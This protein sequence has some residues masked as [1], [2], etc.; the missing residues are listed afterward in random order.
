[1]EDIQTEKETLPSAAAN[2][3]VNFIVMGMAGSGNT[4]FVKRLVSHLQMKGKRHYS[5][6]L[7][8]AIHELQF[9]ANIDIRDSVNYKSIMK[10]Y[11]LGP[12]GGIITSL[13]LFAT[14]FDQVIHLIEKKQEEIDYVIIDT[15]GQIEVFSWSA[16]GQIIS[17][18][19]ACSFP[20]VIVYV[21][22]TVRCKNPNT[23][24][25]NMLYALSIMYKSKLPIIIVFNKVD[26]APHEFAV[27]WMKDFEEFEASLEQDQSYTSSLSR[28]MCLLLEEFY[29]NL[30]SCGVSAVTGLGLDEFMEASKLGVKEYFDVLLPEI[31]KR[32]N[33]NLQ[34][35]AKMESDNLKNFE[36]DH[37]ANKKKVKG[38]V[39]DIDMLK[40]SSV[41]EMIEK[42][43]IH[44]K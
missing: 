24:I 36:D 8:P 16:S 32:K 26:V 35:R 2:K 19:L 7:D 34:N 38:D 27:S 21:I 44:E 29:K 5:I 20:T 1:M 28:S 12:N 13:N 4:T 3:P 39:I 25:S 42:L 33:Q 43:G 18:S 17:E 6:N 15:P 41:E 14:Q 40:G 23:F 11:G 31:E 30:N 9:P 10:K 22:D 37:K